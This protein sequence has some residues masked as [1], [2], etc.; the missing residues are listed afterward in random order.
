MNAA[1]HG[2]LRRLYASGA[3]TTYVVPSDAGP[4]RKYYGINAQ[5]RAMLDAQ[6]GYRPGPGP[7]S[8]LGLGWMSRQRDGQM[9]IGHGG[10]TAGYST[11]VALDPARRV[12]VTVLSNS[13]DFDYADYIGR[14]L[15]DPKWR[16]AVQLPVQVLDGY[17]GTYRL[18]EG[19]DL[20]IAVTDGRLSGQATGQ[21][22]LPL[23]ASGPDQLFFRAINAQLRFNRDPGGRVAGVTLVQG[24]KELTGPRID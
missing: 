3:L 9:L 21:P 14:E 10:G 18:R 11:Y 15:L 13:G 12:G 17:A 7:G 8:Q 19:L 4:H 1:D 24:G 16:T 5:G 6:R 23:F 20:N 2:T 22:R